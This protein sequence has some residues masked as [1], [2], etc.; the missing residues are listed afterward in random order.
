MRSI[1]LG[2]MLVALAACSTNRPAMSP[3]SGNGTYSTQQPTYGGS[4]DLSGGWSDPAATG[5]A[6]QGPAQPGMG[7]TNRQPPPP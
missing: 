6:T 1:L 2:C 7:V 5:P 3:S 4:A